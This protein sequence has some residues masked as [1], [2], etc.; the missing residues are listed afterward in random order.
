MALARFAVVAAAVTALV[1]IT[2]SGRLGSATRDAPRPEP[3]AVTHPAAGLGAAVAGFGDVWV[4]DRARQRLLRVDTGSGHTKA[5]IP[6]DGR[7]ALAASRRAIWAL[8]SGGGYGAGLRGPLLRIDPRTDRVTARIPLGADSPSAPLGFGVQAT[9]GGVWVWGPHEIL[10]IDARGRRDAAP[11]AAGR[12][13]V[14][15]EHGELTG[16][17]A[18]A[19]TLVAGTADGRLLFFDPRSGRRT[20]TARVPFPK[21]SPR[22]LSE[23]RLLFTA[24]GTVG[25]VEL[26]TARVAWTRR[27]GFRA[28]ATLGADGLVWVYSSAEHEHGDRVTALRLATGRVVTSLILPAF[29]STGIAVGAGRVSIATAGGALLTLTRPAADV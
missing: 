18:G 26:A 5:A 20:R 3:I 16:L 9:A 22:A 14:G 19:R 24:S 25:A 2:G 17:A 29:G 15:Y 7:I 8:P 13:A 6:V 23:G 4:D 1:L 10:R 21:P 11:Q 12:I 28:G 27:L